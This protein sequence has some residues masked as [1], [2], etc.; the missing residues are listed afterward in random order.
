MITFNQ[1]GRHGRLGNQMFQYGM[2]MGVAA[3]RGWEIGIPLQARDATTKDGTAYGK[4]R[5]ALLDAFAGIEAHDSSDTDPGVHMVE[6]HSHFIPEVLE[7]PD[8][9]DFK[10]YYQTERYFRHCADAVRRAFVFHDAIVDA[11]RA[12]LPSRRPCVSVHVRRGDYKKQPKKFPLLSPDWYVR[13]LEAA[14]GGH[15][16]VIS[17]DPRWCR[18]AL[19]KHGF[20]SDTTWVSGNDAAT[21]MCL[22]SLCDHHV[23]ANSSFSWWGAWLNASS[24]KVVVY[25]DPWYGPELEHFDTS[26]LPCPEWTSLAR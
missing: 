19:L 20:P 1:L 18:R 8:G 3:A 11:A 6:G 10:G 23:I 13:A 14:G 17:D 24:E 7:A 4:G 12:Q 5:L 26:D 25:P 2:L 22:M 16:V 9:V 15:P 21:D